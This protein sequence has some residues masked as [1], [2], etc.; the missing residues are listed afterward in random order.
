MM[1][2]QPIKSRGGTVRI[3]DT[4]GCGGE[5]QINKAT[6]PNSYVEPTGF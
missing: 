1:A 3:T 5:I 6:P 2:Q 4:S